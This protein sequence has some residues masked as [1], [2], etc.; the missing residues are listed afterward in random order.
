M[1]KKCLFWLVIV[2]ALSA[3]TSKYQA[4]NAHTRINYGYQ[5]ILLNKGEIHPRYLLIYKGKSGDQN[6]II[7]QYWHQRAKELC[8]NGY[9][10][11]RHH[12]GVIHGSMRTPVNGL[13]V[14][15]GTQ[16][17]IDKGEIRCKTNNGNNTL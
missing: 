13:M 15:V 9:D 3:C 14:T 1:L 8:I 17:P 11:I 10:V 12:Q 5:E 7:T 2:L 6:S 16:T 4:L